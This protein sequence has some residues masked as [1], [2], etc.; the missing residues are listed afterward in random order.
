[1]FVYI[2][3]STNHSPKHREPYRIPMI[4]QN[5]RHHEIT[6]QKPTEKTPQ[7]VTIRHIVINQT[8]TSLDA[9]Y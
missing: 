5:S 8:S 3:L 2:Y 9:L 1:M 6:A 4:L 7:L